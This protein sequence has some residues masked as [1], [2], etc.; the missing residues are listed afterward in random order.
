MG[1][2]T[3]LLPAGV[4]ERRPLRLDPTPRPCP[5]WPASA[6]APEWVRLRTSTSR[7]REGLGVAR[8]PSE[9]ARWDKPLPRQGSPLS[10]AADAP[11]SLPQ[12]EA[13]NNTVFGA[14]R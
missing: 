2:S 11:R 14:V 4:L 6:P 1:S 9:A 13:N 8:S 7:W 12:P 10:E 3:P 5:P